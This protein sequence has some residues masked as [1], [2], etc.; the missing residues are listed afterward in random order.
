MGGQSLNLKI[1]ITGDGSNLKA[2]VVGA[3]SSLKRLASQAETSG[4]RADKAHTKTRKGVDQL[5][6]SVSATG[7]KVK[8]LSSSLA[9][10]SVAAK[11]ASSS[12]RN[13]AGSLA[14]VQGPLGPVAGRVTALSAI[15]GRVSI[16]GLFAA[17]GVTALSVIL[18]KSVSAAAAYESQMGRLKA[19][20]RGTGGAAKLTA[21]EIDKFSIQLGERTL[22]SARAVRDAAGALL[23]FRSISGSQFKETLTLSQDLAATM[24]TDL[25]G[26]VVQLAKALEQPEIGL[27]MLRRAGVSFTE[28]Q[29]TQII[30]L[31]KSGRQF[32]A[33]QLI[34]DSVKKTVHGAGAGESQG[35]T[36]AIDTLGERWTRMLEGIGGTPAIMGT[37]VS[38][39]KALSRGVLSLVHNIEAI[40]AGAL[41]AVKLAVIGV[42]VRMAAA[43]LAANTLSFSMV[44]LRAASLG[45][46]MLYKSGGVKAL[47]S[48]PFISMAAATKAA[49]IGVSKLKIASS[50]LFAAYAGWEIGRY[51]SDQFSIVKQAA[52]M[53][54]NGLDTVW[55]YIKFGGK[56]AGAWVAFTWN[57]TMDSLKLA[58][59]SFVQ[60]V[61]SVLDTLSFNTIPTENMK[62]YAA[63]LK[64]GSVSA[65][66]FTAHLKALAEERDK[67]IKRKDAFYLSEFRDAGNQPTQSNASDK[68]DNSSGGPN[69]PDSA[70]DPTKKLFSSADALTRKLSDTYKSS[71]ERISDRYSTMFDKLEA[72]GKP[73]MKKLE[74]LST[75]YATFTENS[76][77]KQEEKR[78][79]I[80]SQGVQSI[81]DSLLNENERRVQAYTRRKNMLQK[82]I[83]DEV[84]TKKRGLSLLAQLDK[85]HADAQR[86]QDRTAMQ[87]KLG[88]VSQG[89]GGVAALMQSGSKKAFKIGKVAAIAQAGVNGISAAIAAWDKGMQSGGIWGAAAMTGASILKTASMI[90]K[91]ESVKFG[92]G[93]ASVSAGGASFASGGGGA[94]TTI[95]TPV[96]NPTQ[97]PTTPAPSS[98][99][100]QAS[101][102]PIIQ[103]TQHI[104]APGSQAGQEQAIAVAAQVAT[105]QAVAHIDNDFQTN[106]PLRQALAV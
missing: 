93:V 26:S 57:N 31:A 47:L 66:Q 74:A 21:Q 44:G 77:L 41:L 73:G 67:N 15:L 5:G 51:L 68:T 37:A 53:M 8:G 56:S 34:L 85:K 80:L 75:A 106:G 58:F 22:T 94:V 24:R 92:G 99:V 11:S 20:I 13:F 103:I 10:E 42:T 46:F 63:A 17:G 27:T 1:R 59:A 29:R 95:A 102:R 23:S 97:R 86:K 3:E 79:S 33:Q 38:S 91:L 69:P 82:A 7:R 19:L 49:F 89:L 88:L 96:F 36:G 64:A 76:W 87:A 83:D 45:L 35:L 65:Q 50:V 90:S 98:G 25:R 84:I 9:A 105:Q 60:G 16:A 18:G 70:V 61:A 62:N 81:A 48:A 4:A 71:F 52:I 6:K 101:G 32:E 30:V 40:T 72:L 2:E 28:Q 12:M 78:K 55:E 100:T 43:A 104:T 39:I 14:V 54:A